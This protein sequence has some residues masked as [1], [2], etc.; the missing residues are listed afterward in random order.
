MSTFVMDID[1]TISH[2]KYLTEFDRYDYKNGE[3]DLKV[4]QKIRDLA[5]EGHT[6]I[7]FT[8]RG[9]RTFKGDV[10]TLE[11]YHRP[12]LEDW[13]GRHEV[14][15]HQL[16]FGKPWFEDMYYV[17]DRALTINQFVNSKDYENDLEQNQK[18]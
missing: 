17:D 10:N 7:L 3:P 12:I 9:M 6:I 13:L 8:A 2:A 4:I 11:E 18:R 15:Y 1:S 16:I 14:P 5:E